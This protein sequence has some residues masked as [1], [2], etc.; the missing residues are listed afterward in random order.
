MVIILGLFKTLHTLPESCN[1]PEA[2]Q[3]TDQPEELAAL[4]PLPQQALLPPEAP[5]EP[6]EP[7]ASLMPADW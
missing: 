2:H 3:A 5:A 4:V 1:Q 6:A 7:V